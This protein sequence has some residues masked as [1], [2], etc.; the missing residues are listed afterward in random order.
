MSSLRIMDRQQEEEEEGEEEAEEVFEE[1]TVDSEC[2]GEQPE[3]YPYASTLVDYGPTCWE[4]GTLHKRGAKH[5]TATASAATGRKSG[6]TAVPRLADEALYVKMVSDMWKSGEPG[7][8]FRAFVEQAKELLKDHDITVRESLSVELYMDT[9][10]DAESYPTITAVVTKLPLRRTVQDWLVSILRNSCERCAHLARSTR[11]IKFDADNR[12]RM[13]VCCLKNGAKAESLFEYITGGKKLITH[14]LCSI[15]MTSR[16]LSTP[17][18]DEYTRTLYIPE[19][20]GDKIPKS[21][22][23]S[24]NQA[25]A[26][27]CRHKEQHGVESVGSRVD[28]QDSLSP[29]NILVDKL[30]RMG[31]DVVDISTNCCVESDGDNGDVGPG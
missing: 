13:Y 12:R 31:C 15:D 1:T 17:Q 26:A 10:I 24:V 29:R 7:L 6:S 20:S 23:P 19:W 30:D 8:E 4:G 22:I 2:D 11:T 5:S 16:R 21:C 28:E 14:I 18:F 3:S 25:L 27:A 9:L